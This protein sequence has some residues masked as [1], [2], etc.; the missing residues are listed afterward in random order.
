MAHQ[1]GGM[2]CPGCPRAFLY[3]LIRWLRMTTGLG[4][5]PHAMQRSLLTRSVL[6]S[7]VKGRDR[8]AGVSGREP[9]IRRLLDPSCDHLTLHEG[10]VPD[11][12][13]LCAGRT[14][15]VSMSSEQD[16]RGRSRR[17]KPLHPLNSMH[18]STDLPEVLH[19]PKHLSYLRGTIIDLP[20]LRVPFVAFP[21]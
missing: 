10:D 16:S 6:L 13:F 5:C 12:A 15:P 9:S 14:T 20:S 8:S 4:R 2:P 21:V 18:G 17:R 3:R 1:S 19:K 7:K 11:L